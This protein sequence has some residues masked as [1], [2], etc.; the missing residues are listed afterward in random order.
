MKF[1]RVIFTL[2]IAIVL[3]QS[4]AKYSTLE[5]YDY[6]KTYLKAWLRESGYGDLQPNESGVYMLEE[7]EGTGTQSQSDTTLCRVQFTIRH[8]DNEVYATTSKEEAIVQGTYSDSIYYA[9]EVWV[10]GNYE[11]YSCLEKE[12]RNMKSGGKIKIIVPPELTKIEYPKEYYQNGV[13][14][15]QQA[16]FTENMIYEIELVEAIDNMNSYTALQLIEYKNKNFPE[17][18]EISPGFY[19][20]KTKSVPDADTI[21]NGATLYT[22][23]VGKHLDG[24]CFDTNISDT[25]KK[26]GRYFEGLPSLKVGY[27]TDSTNYFNEAGVI[28]GYAKAL[29]Y[30]KK[31][32]TGIAFFNA[33]YGYGRN[34]SDNIR[35]FDPL[36]FQITIEDVQ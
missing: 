10:M 16:D 4:C 7:M 26:Y 29:R 33:N 22:R 13:T 31:G 28:M 20:C 3:L 9:P 23:Y 34:G 17:A 2:F 30:L 12:V 25:A 6:Q 36:M 35:A 5:T 27:K 11:V 18:R 1:Y 8:L 15:I 24:F 14:V 19:F 21:P 32:E